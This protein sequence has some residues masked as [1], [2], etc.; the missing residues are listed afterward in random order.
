[1]RFENIFIITSSKLSDTKAGILGF[2]TFLN[3][4][5]CFWC[6]LPSIT[7]CPMSIMQSEITSN[8]DICSTTFLD[9]QQI[10]IKNPHDRW[11]LLWQHHD[12]RHFS[13]RHKPYQVWT[14]QINIAWSENIIRNKSDV[15]HI[16]YNEWNAV[17]NTW[18]CECGC[19]VWLEGGGGGGVFRL[20]I[21][22]YLCDS[23][24]WQV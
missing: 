17:W 8:P 12:Q 4:V 16:H 10:N 19:V 24:L 15:A 21:L 6:L 3:A 9:K 1:M 23:I 22:I 11:P 18:K 7:L 14:A 5:I 13:Y 20:W 2:H